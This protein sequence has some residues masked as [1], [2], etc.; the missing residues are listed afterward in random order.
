MRSVYLRPAEDAQ[1][2]QLAHELNV[3]KSDLIRS[4]ISVKLLQWLRSN[5]RNEILKDVEHG[6]RDEAAIRSGRRSRRRGAPDPLPVDAEEVAME[7]EEP[8]APLARRRPEKA[9][10]G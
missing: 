8:H 10:G 7:A 1:L 9:L 2:R 5:D 4:A 3:T 6:R